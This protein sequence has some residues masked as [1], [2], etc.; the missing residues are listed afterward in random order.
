MLPSYDQQYTVDLSAERHPVAG[1]NLQPGTKIH[2]EKKAVLDFKSDPGAP[3]PVQQTTSTTTIYDPKNVDCVET[4]S[5]CTAACETAAARTYA[6]EVSAVAKGRACTGP[7]DCKTGEGACQAGSSNGG[8]GGGGGENDSGGDDRID[9]DDAILVFTVAASTADGIVITDGT[10]EYRA[11]TATSGNDGVTFTV[12][13]PTLPFL[14]ITDD[15]IILLEESLM[16]VAT[17][18]LGYPPKKFA[19]EPGDDEGTTV[20]IFIN[21]T[22]EPTPEDGG[23]G[24]TIGIAVGVVVFLMLIAVL[25]WMRKEQGGNGGGSSADGGLAQIDGSRMVE[26]PAY[27]V[28][29]PVD[30]SADTGYLEVSN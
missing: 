21:P 2:L 23:S 18:T 26:N 29:E 20:I 8:G 22:D 4:I 9:V 17:T 6:L 30:S 10:K 11:T 1:L 16:A 25:L 5:E 12:A 3:C 24:T 13:F 27:D 19:F 7:T 28:S 14:N 15:T